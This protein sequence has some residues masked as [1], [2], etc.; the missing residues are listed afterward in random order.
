MPG[1][2][3]GAARGI[4]ACIV[5]VGAVE[6]GVDALDVAVVDVVGL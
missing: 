1:M 6:R 5:V 3:P 2:K 4:M